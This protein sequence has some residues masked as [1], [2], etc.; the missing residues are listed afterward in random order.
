MVAVYSN[1]ALSH[2][3]TFEWIR[4]SK[5]LITMVL[6]MVDWSLTSCQSMGYFRE[7]TL[8]VYD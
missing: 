4:R 7:L 8:V 5:V 3:T 1:N 2:T 6:D